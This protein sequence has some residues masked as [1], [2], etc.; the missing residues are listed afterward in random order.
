[1]HKV[2]DL[3]E[4]FDIKKKKSI[5]LLVLIIGVWAGYSAINE[6]TF[7]FEDCKSF[8]KT[9]DDAGL[10]TDYGMRLYFMYQYGDH[11]GENP[12]RA[13]TY[14]LLYLSEKVFGDFRVIPFISSGLFIALTYFLTTEIT[15]RNYTGLIAVLFLLH[16]P[17]FFKY[18]LVL[19]YPNFWATLFFASLFFSYKS[20]VWLLSPVTIIVSFGAKIINLMNLPAV[21]VFVCLTENKNRKKLLLV[22][23]TLVALVCTV[24]LSTSVLY[25]P[26]W[27]KFYFIFIS[28]FKF[29]PMEFLWWLGMWSVELFT[30]KI[31]LL[32]IFLMLPCLFILKKGKV[33]NASA[34]LAM[35][36]IFILQPAFI[37]GLTEYTNEDY[38]Y[39]HLVAFVGIAL[40]LV[41]ANIKTLLV[42]SDKIFNLKKL[43]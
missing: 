8:G 42:T 41:I 29:Q 15:K 27:H 28:Q 31:T 35:L 24:V 26:L 5:L 11:R 17:I 34:V 20:R 30:D 16:S 32:L 19:T 9:V 37:S 38:R 23:T 14:E 10:C 3:V 36:I 22:Y 40:S 12:L 43:T 18:D 6:L 39:L 1:L 13:V 7:P 21:I 33:K 25:P 2:I 4:S